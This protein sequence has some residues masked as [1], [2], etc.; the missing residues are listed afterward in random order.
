MSIL[1]NACRCCMNETEQMENLFDKF[2][3]VGPKIDPD[4]TYSDAIYL[5]TNIELDVVANDDITVGFPQYICADC[6]HELR[7]ALLFRAKCEETDAL[8]R[9][10]IDNSN[11][12]PTQTNAD[13]GQL[14]NLIIEQIECEVGNTENS[15]GQPHQESQETNRSVIV[16]A[17]F[18]IFIVS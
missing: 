17:L 18:W 10:H 6:L 1:A 8:L 16:C 7:A 15:S 2:I 4:L 13:E 3:D 5:C 9:K 14:E 12:Q 11:I